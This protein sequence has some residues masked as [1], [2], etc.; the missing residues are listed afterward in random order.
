[1]RWMQWCLLWFLQFFVCRKVC[2]WL[3]NKQLCRRLWW[4]RLFFW[5][6]NRVHR[7]LWF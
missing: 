4:F 6:W 1:M 3:W 7:W 5:M 2:R